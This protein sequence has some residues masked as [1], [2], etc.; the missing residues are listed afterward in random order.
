MRM[1]VSKFV[2]E[3]GVQPRGGFV[4]PSELVVSSIIEDYGSIVADI[5]KSYECGNID[6]RYRGLIVDYLTRALV[7]LMYQDGTSQEVAEKAFKVSLRGASIAG[8]KDIAMEFVTNIADALSIHENDMKFILEGKMRFG[9]HVLTKNALRLV[10][11][12]SY[13]RGG[14][15]DEKVED[16]YPNDADVFAIEQMVR[17]SFTYFH[18]R[19][20]DFLDTGVSFMG[21]YTKKLCPCDC[22]FTTT[23]GIVDIKTSKREPTAKDTFQL[24]LYYILGLQESVDKIGDDSLI[25]L[26]PRLNKVYSW[27]LHKLTQHMVEEV[28][29]IIGSDK[30]TNLV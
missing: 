1:P 19:P 23:S 12:D 30:L 10:A 24:L 15:Y 7:H 3:S 18:D 5:E 2:Q 28:E 29:K 20:N 8:K 9:F 22:D 14:S 4:P 6:S 16:I 27:S 21:S 25:I 11:Y 17:I 13:V 26:N